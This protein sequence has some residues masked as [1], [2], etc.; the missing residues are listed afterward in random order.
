[1]MPPAALIC[2][3]A[4]LQAF[5]AFRPKNAFC[6]VNACRTPAVTGYVPPLEPDPLAELPPD[7]PDPPD[8]LDPLDEHPAA[9]IEA[10][11]ATA[12]A[13]HH[14]LF[15]IIAQGLHPLTSRKSVTVDLYAD[16]KR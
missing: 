11:T 12:Q 14:L 3:A 16:H 15:S 7:P 8:P 10:V 13:S 6:P 9:A 5:S 2:S 4:A 1:M